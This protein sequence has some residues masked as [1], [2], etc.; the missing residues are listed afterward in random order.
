M[1]KH[2]NIYVADKGNHRIQSFSPKGKFQ[3]V[4]LSRVDGL[5][6]PVDVALAQTG[7]LVTITERGLVY[8]VTTDCQLS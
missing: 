3:G 4:L 1:D 8:V 5:E 6:A 7:N 2:G